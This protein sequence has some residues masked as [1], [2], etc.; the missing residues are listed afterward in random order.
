MG[1]ADIA[2]IPRTKEE[3]LKWSFCHQAHHVD[4]LRKIYENYGLVLDGFV[5]DPID[6]NNTGVWDY[7]H[8]LMHSQMDVVLGI[9]GNNLLG[10]NFQDEAIL[11]AW[12]W[13]NQNEHQQASAI[14]NV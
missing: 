13:L 7:N 6:P 12:V 4:I 11:E 2:S 5:L 8:A 9:D 14:L 1:L 10:V 3:L